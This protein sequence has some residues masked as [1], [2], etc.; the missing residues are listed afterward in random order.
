V[1]VTEEGK[2]FG[3]ALEVQLAG[4]PQ[5]QFG[6]EVA[7]QEGRSQHYSQQQVS[8]WVQGNEPNP[9]QA[10][11]IEKALGVRPGTLTRLLGYLPLDAR[12]TKTVNEAVAADPS[13]ESDSAPVTGS[14]LPPAS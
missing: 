6:G 2:V 11:A 8:N 1:P 13:L 3:R 4:R 10:I 9:R 12:T 14:D 5:G 7:K